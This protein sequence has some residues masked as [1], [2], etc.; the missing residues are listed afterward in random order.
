LINI[1]FDSQKK[2]FKWCS[3]DKPFINQITKT[4]IRTKLKLFKNGKPDEA[5]KL[6]KSIKREIR[7]LAR[8][9]YKNKVKNFFT[10]KP[11]NW[12]SEVKKLCGRRL[13]QLNFNLPESPDVTANN[14]NKILASIVQSLPALSDQIP[15]GALFP[16]FSRLRQEEE[17]KN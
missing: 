13:G 1:K 3:S 14:L 10:N 12:Y 17:L 16:L 7:K 11:K 15:K 4:L 6:R 9:Y 2:L 8:S 5:N